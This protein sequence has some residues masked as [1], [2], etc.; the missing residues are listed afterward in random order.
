MSE[1][2]KARPSGA[3]GMLSGRAGA[4]RDAIPTA[5]EGDALLDMLFDDAIKPPEDPGNLPF[6][7]N[8]TVAA[9]Q[10]Y[11]RRTP[12]P[13]TPIPGIGEAPGQV[14][15]PPGWATTPGGASPASPKVRP[16]EDLPTRVYAA[17]PP[18]FDDDDQELPVEG[19]RPR[20]PQ[21]PIPPIPPTPPVPPRA[22]PPRPSGRGAPPAAAREPSY[23]EVEESDLEDDRTVIGQAAVTEDAFDP[24]EMGGFGDDEGTEDA[25]AHERMTA[26][27]DDFG[28]A[29]ELGIAE[30]AFE[31]EE[32]T[33]ARYEANQAPAV[34]A[35]EPPELDL[36]S[37]D[38]GNE[39]EAT[40]TF[41]A[42]DH[43]ELAAS[44]PGL[45]EPIV[46]EAYDAQDSQPPIIK[47]TRPP[48]APGGLDDEREASAA[49]AATPGL[50]DSFLERAAWL[51]EE[52]GL[53]PDKLQRAR[54]LMTASE[55]YAIAGEDGA[56]MDL[57]T[58]AYQLAPN[59]PLVIR[60][61]RGLIARTHGHGETLETLDS[62]TRHMPTPE[63]RVH[64]A[65]MASEVARVVNGDDA[66]AKKRAE[67]ALRASPADPRATLQRF[68]ES[69]A[70]GA[71]A[72]ALSKI[73]PSDPEAHQSLA[74][75]FF[76]VVSLRAPEPAAPGE[77]RH[78]F[79][80][81]GAARA[82]LSAGDRRG[83]LAALA[84][85]RGSSFGPA[86]GWLGAALATSHPD[87]RTEAIGALRAAAEGGDP[88]GAR[89]ALAAISVETGESVDLRDREAFG[90]ADR[91]AL[92]A[93][94][95]ARP[96]P[97]GTA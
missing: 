76:Q 61:Y 3:G 80:A 20:P 65:W 38:E 59:V 10:G 96:G 79:A 6:D 73:K 27:R 55:L 45:G 14:V 86:A 83:T 19:P 63:G 32:T 33:H 4:A 64:A 93:L 62:E 22:P 68:V 11:G 78:A 66:G 1:D 57:A 5:D 25:D 94:D 82:S 92:A 40:R 43:P 75:G 12:T 49:V 85:L 77:Q 52:A 26:G 90:P 2:K 97:Q 8:A 46:H 95:A 84:Q 58:Q 34:Q 28:L 50:R 37:L 42:S 74:N 88:A 56:A 9:P 18:D 44:H 54:L 21:A 41:H 23:E 36:G 60:Q 53:R 87:T 7:P 72:A 81:L 47:S 16:N 70:T 69:L 91:I 15:A 31:A 89:R 29:D 35:P 30:P 39:E 13:P 67:I 17:P 24:M 71:D 48:L 51:A